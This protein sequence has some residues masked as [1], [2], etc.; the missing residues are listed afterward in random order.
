MCAKSM[1]STSV[2]ISVGNY[3][4][5]RTSEQLENYHSKDTLIISCTSITAAPDVVSQHVTYNATSPLLSWREPP[6]RS[7]TNGEHVMDLLAPETNSPSH[8]LWAEGGTTGTA[9]YKSDQ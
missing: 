7:Y 9:P 6:K 2:D 1:Q 8:G 3:G 5:K 4:Q